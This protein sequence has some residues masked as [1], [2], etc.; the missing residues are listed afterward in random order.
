MSPQL[1]RRRFLQSSALSTLALSAGAAPAKTDDRPNIL[2]IL[3]DD[4][5]FSDPGCFG[6]EIDTPNINRLA[7]NGLRFTQFYNCARCC[8]TRASL[9]TGLY[10]HQVGLT[11]NGRSLT[12]DGA[13]IAEA[14]KTAGY[15]TAMSGKWHLSETKPLKDAALHQ[16]WLDHQYDPGKPFA[17]IDTYPINR[18]F[19]R[20]YGNIW[21]VVDYFDPFSLVEGDQPVKEVPDDYYHTDAITD[22]AISYINDMSKN[23]APF[24]LYLAHCAPHWPLHARKEDIKK[25]QDRYKNGWDALRTDR[26]DRMVKLGLFDTS[27]T[28]LPP[29]QVLGKSWNELTEDEK[30]FMADKMAVH[31]AMVDRVD[32]N[33]GR[34][35]DTLEESGE[36]D[37][38]VIFFL[39]DN[40]A[41]PEIM[42]QAGYDRT[43]QTRE[44]EHVE[45]IRPEDVGSETSY[46][47]IGPAWANAA[48]TPFRYWKAQT[49]EG[50]CHTPM[51]VHWPKGLKTSPNSLTEQAGH[52]IDI[53]PTCL[54]L[55]GAKPLAFYNGHPVLPLEGESLLPILEGKQRKGH[56]HMFFEHE[57]GRAVIEG[58]WKLVANKNKTKQWELYDLSKD[59]TET[60]NL[61]EKYP[62]RV[63][64]MSAA[65]DAWAKHVGLING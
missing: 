30:E 18:G 56:E 31:A 24:F 38:T 29:V 13:T 23:D 28:P 4:M 49:F 6:G 39:A 7:K 37:N 3:V 19:D 62:E 48:N 33:I 35:L 32:Q 14:L 1:N 9:L 47:C 2:V 60:N 16:K 44:G 26:F 27:N 55:A 22:K 25:Y 53:M 65:W 12:R 57:R 46:S 17:P 63:Q 10:Q 8:P 52:V 20:Y 36:L 51:I 5:G 54:D 42:T 64:E 59:R 41:S 50:G 21:G 43:S 40:G 15:Q 61:V 34:V 11:L 58:H 45:Y